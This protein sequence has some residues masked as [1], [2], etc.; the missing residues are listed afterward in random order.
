MMVASCGF[1]SCSPS[2]YPALACL[3]AQVAPLRAPAVPLV[4]HDPYFSV[5]SFDDQLTGSFT[6]HW[7]GAP[8]PLNGL[9][10]IDGKRTGTPASNRRR[11]PPMEQTAA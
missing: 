5:W 7:T 8:Q 6:R 2:S 10:R 11:C 9:I 4:T 1:E 3:P